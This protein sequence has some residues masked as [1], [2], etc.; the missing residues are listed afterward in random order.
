MACHAHIE[1]GAGL[2]CGDGECRPCA[3]FN[4]RDLMAI[5]RFPQ[6]TCNASYS[7]PAH[8]TS[9]DVVLPRSSRR[10]IAR[11]SSAVATS[12][13]AWLAAPRPLTILLRCPYPERI[14]LALSAFS[15]VHGVRL[16]IQVESHQQ[17]QLCKERCADRCICVQH[18]ANV[19]FQHV[20]I[21]DLSEDGSDLLYAH[22]DAWLHLPRLLQSPWYASGDIAVSPSLGV[23]ITRTPTCI[24]VAAIGR[25]RPVNSTRGPTRCVLQCEHNNWT[26][27]HNSLPQ[28]R[29]A[30]TQRDLA[31]CCYSWADILFLPA[32]ALRAF[33]SLASSFAKV[34]H[35]VAIPT[36]LHA[37]WANASI[38]W[39]PSLDCLGGCC[40]DVPWNAAVQ[41]SMCAHRLK[42]QRIANLTC[43]L[44]APSPPPPAA[45]MHRALRHAAPED[46]T[47][48]VAGVEYVRR[49]AFMPDEGALGALAA[50]AVPKQA[51]LLRHLVRG[52]EL[53]TW[54]CNN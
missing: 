24:E 8:R 9:N 48:V 18:R 32:S 43:T 36:I 35:E 5:D 2:W 3:T 22:I 10:A 51:Q 30:A 52:Q 17:M 31:W 21:K 44:D 33:R 15:C 25:C 4:V 1:C 6:E 53:S 7:P 26:W 50:G 12:P 16:C 23:G 38:R 19:R 49:G 37:L 14:P 41:Q 45:P 13:T 39:E 40:A 54:T 47:Y 46:D 27:W 29:I 42:L 28:C 34:F 11:H 20:A